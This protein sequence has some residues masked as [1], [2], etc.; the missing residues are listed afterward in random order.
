MITPTIRDTAHHHLLFDGSIVDYIGKALGEQAVIAEV[1]RLD[2]N[3]NVVA[4]VIPPA[5][6]RT[7]RAGSAGFR[8]HCGRGRGVQ[9]STMPTT[10]VSSIRPQPTRPRSGNHHES[11]HCRSRRKSSQSP[12][13]TDRFQERRVTPADP[14]LTLTLRDYVAALSQ[15]SS[16]GGVLW[17]A[18][19]RPQVCTRAQATSELFGANS[20]PPPKTPRSDF[21]VAP[22]M[23]GRETRN[24]ANIICAY[25]RSAATERC[26]HTNLPC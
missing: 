18:R 21:R 19:N 22:A 13:A 20:D 7:I 3:A 23:T 15:E 11:D 12:V 25:V 2:S 14:A 8:H 9:A 24:V 10:L 17:T 5:F 16:V 26:V 1:K 4:R 6:P